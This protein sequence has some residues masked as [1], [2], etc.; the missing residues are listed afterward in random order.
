MEER[1]IK[2]LATL[3]RFH[4]AATGRMDEN[5][6]ADDWQELSQLV[7]DTV[8]ILRQLAARAAA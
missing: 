1:D 8:P 7:D 4:R 3:D 2:G 5:L 6:T